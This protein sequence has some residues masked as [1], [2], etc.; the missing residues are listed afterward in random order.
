MRKSLVAS[1]LAIGLIICSAGAASADDRGNHDAIWKAG[2]HGADSGAEWGE[3]IGDMASNG[4]LKPSGVSEG[5]HDAKDQP[6]P[7][8]NR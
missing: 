3:M 4:D 7:G 6:V 8:Q 2:Q 1:G 5:V